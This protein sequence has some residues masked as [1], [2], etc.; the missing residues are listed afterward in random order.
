MRRKL[1]RDLSDEELRLA[2]GQQIGLTFLIPAA[3]DRHTANPLVSGDM[4]EGA[5]VQYVLLNACRAG[6]DADQV[7]CLD[8][9]VRRFHE[10][11]AALDAGWRQ[12][13]LPSIKIALEHYRTFRGASKSS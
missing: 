5:V 6:L 11:S 13:C 3:L 7:S 9:I 2:I 1:L 10:A 4:Y 8:Q 12:E